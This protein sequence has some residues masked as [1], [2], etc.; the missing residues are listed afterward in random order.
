MRIKL[1]HV[2]L[3]LVGWVHAQQAPF[4]PRVWTNNKGRTVEAAFVDFSG[5]N[6]VIQLKDGARSSVP[7]ATLSDADQ[8]YLDQV[9]ATAKVEGLN[10]AAPV[11]SGP[12]APAWPT[13]VLTSNPKFVVVTEGLQDAAARRFHYTVGSFEFVS[14]APLGKTVMAEV[15]SDFL[16]TEQFF[17]IQCWDWSPKPRNKERFLIYL[18]ETKED[19][20]EIGG[21]DNSAS[22]MLDDGSCVI[23]FDPLGLK[24]VG[25]RYQFDARAKIE[26]RITNVVAQVMLWDGVGGWLEHWTYQGMAHLLRFVAYQNDGSVRCQ[27]LLPSFRKA[28]PGMLEHYKTTPNLERMLKY[29]RTPRSELRGDVLQFRRDQQVDSLMLV[30]YFGFLDGDGSGKRLHEFYQSIFARARKTN[31]AAAA[32]KLLEERG[33]VSATP[34]QLH[35]WLIDGRDDQALGK[36]MIE[37]FK[38]VGVK[39]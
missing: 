21:S 32:K 22:D 34:Q 2:L 19:Y 30:F 14:T 39:L 1:L 17:K 9:R 27:D 33:Q 4:P 16:I 18:A 8:K 29:L 12:S 5:L 11:K 10:A 36:E 3:L 28:L 7:L 13:D 38:L 20:I 26:G 25:Q 31:D 24:K 35:E 15:A 23:G 6:V 37:K